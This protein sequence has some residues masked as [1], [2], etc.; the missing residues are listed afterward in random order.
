MEA[1]CTEKEPA[2]DRS[3]KGHVYMKIRSF[4]GDMIAPALGC[5]PS[6]KLADIITAA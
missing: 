6:T 4:N 1:A 2:F 3:K 5:A